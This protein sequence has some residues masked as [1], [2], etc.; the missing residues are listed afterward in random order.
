M[1]TLEDD[2][3]P[4]QPPGGPAWRKASYSGPEGDCV[5]AAALTTRHVGVRD[6]KDPLGL[7]LAL[8]AK[9]WRALLNNIR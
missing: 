3:I 7:V 2:P 5:E 1:A 9:A 8:D 6:S 4:P